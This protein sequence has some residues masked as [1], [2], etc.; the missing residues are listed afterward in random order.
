L[1]LHFLSISCGQI[2]SAVPVKQKKKNR[3]RGGRPLSEKKKEGGGKGG[4]RG[5][6][7]GTTVSAGLIPF[8]NNSLLFLMIGM[9]LKGKGEEGKGKKGPS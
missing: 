6:M 2:H 8:S 9:M 1:F 7:H 3:K 4:K 5:E